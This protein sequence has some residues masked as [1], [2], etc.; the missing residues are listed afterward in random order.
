[1]SSPSELRPCRP[2]DAFAVDPPAEQSHGLGG[3]AGA[4]EKRRDGD[5]IG[6]DA[7]RFLE[8]FAPR[9]LFWRLARLDDAGHAFQQPGVPLRGPRTGTKLFDQHHAVA[10]GV[11]GEHRGD[12]AAFE[13]LAREHRPHAAGE[14][15]VAQAVAVETEVAVVGDL[16]ADYVNVSGGHLIPSPVVAPFGNP[17]KGFRRQL[18]SG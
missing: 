7:A 10:N 13:N 1:M 18:P 15:S 16:P 12:L 8:R 9:Q 6:D 17:A 4:R 5:Q 11:H 2:P 3:C 14:L